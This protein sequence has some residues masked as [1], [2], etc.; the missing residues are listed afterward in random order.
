[1][2]NENP[3]MTSQQFGA[4]VLQLIN[5]ASFKGADIDTAAALRQQA[6]RLESGVDVLVTAGI[7]D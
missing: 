1:M 6:E 5:S 4:L 3:D 7:D 2:T